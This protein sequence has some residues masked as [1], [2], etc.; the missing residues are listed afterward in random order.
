MSAIIS[1]NFERIPRLMISLASA[2]YESR[3]GDFSNTADAFQ[4]MMYYI[5]ALCCEVKMMYHCE[6][7]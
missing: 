4:L 3:R 6:A 1:M 5:E 2:A 7:S